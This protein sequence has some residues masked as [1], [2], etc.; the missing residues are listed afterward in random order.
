[1]RSERIL[2]RFAGVF[3]VAALGVIAMAIPSMARAG[4]DGDVRAGV[5]D[6]DQVAIGGG[7]LAQVG[8]GSRWYFNPNVELAMGDHKDAVSMNGDFH[9][10][11]AT[12]RG[13]AFWVGGGP[14]LL[15]I[16][17]EGEDNQ[18]D[19]GLNVLTGIGK[20]SGQVRPFAQVR[21]TVADENQVTIAGGF[22]F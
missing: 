8:N 20:K 19:V 16:D 10:D 14:A 18:T 11:L 4:L 22:R 3:G 21:G 2:R 15:V 9:Y 17:R 5:T 13:P 12:G 1:M 7:V 6:G